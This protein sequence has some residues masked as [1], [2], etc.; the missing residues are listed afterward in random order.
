MDYNLRTKLQFNPNFVSGISFTPY[1]VII[2]ILLGKCRIKQS[3]FL[4][5]SIEEGTE[6]MEPV[7][8]NPTT[9]G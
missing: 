8:C 7:H 4:L 6:G 9:S 2:S 3:D 1:V 5:Y